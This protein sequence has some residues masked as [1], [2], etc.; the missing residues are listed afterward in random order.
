MIVIL[1]VPVV[2]SVFV[3]RSSA[4]DNGLL[5]CWNF[6]EGSGSTATDSS[7]NGNTGAL[8]NGPAWVD[9]KRGKALSFDGRS[10][11]MSYPT[12]FS[13]GISE[14]SVMAWINSPLNQSGDII[15]HGYGG[16]F[17][18]RTGSTSTRTNI[19]SFEVHL[20]D[21]IWYASSSSVLF[22]NT[23]YFVAGVWSK[24][25]SLR[26][27]IDGVLESETAVPSLDLTPLSAGWDASIGVYD[28]AHYGIDFWNGIV[29]EARIYNRALTQ[30]EVQNDMGVTRT[31]EH[32][33]DFSVDTGL[34]T[35]A[36]TAY[37]DSAEE[38][39]VLT[40]AV[41]AQAGAI[42]F[43]ETVSSSFTACFK[44]WIG[45]TT[46]TM[47]DGLAMMFY[48]Q[49][50]LSLPTGGYL[51]FSS[52]G[53]GV[54][55]DTFQN[56]WDV[57][58]SHVALI[59]D[60]VENHLAQVNDA[61]VRDQ[62]WHNV[63][64]NVVPSSVNVYIDG[65]RILQ[66][67]GTLDSTHNGFGFT[68]ATGEASWPVNDKHIIDDFSIKA[69]ASEFDV[70]ISPA[71]INTSI[72]GAADCTITI[73]NQRGAADV[74]NIS[75]WG[76]NSTW[77]SLSS[78][79]VSLMS[80]EIVHIKL[81]ISVPEDPSAVGSYE[82]S[83]L[84]Y[85]S[86]RMEKNVSS[87]LIV[88]L[89]P[90]IT[91]L[92]PN[93]GATIAST[94]ILFSWH[95]SSNASS[96]VYI[97]QTNDPTFNKAVGEPGSTHF[98][99]AYNL[100]RNADYVWYAYG[101]TTYGNASS[102]TRT[103]HVS[104]GV[105]FVQDEY[106]FN[107]ERD[108]AQHGTVAVINTD[109]VSH[110]L[111]LQA[112]NP[113]EDLIVGF[114]GEGSVDQ[115][116]TLSPSETK[117]VDFFIHAQDAMQQNYTFTAKLTNLGPEE[118]VD[119]ALI[120]VTVRQP[121]TNLTLTEVSTDP[122]TLSKTIV[123][124]NYGDTLTDLCIDTGDELNGKV[125]FQPAV[126][127]AY[128][129][130]GGSLTFKA[131]P[132]LT[133]DFAGC[134][135]LIL[136]I[137][138]GQ[139][140]ASLQVNFTLPPGKSV[141][142][143][144]IPQ[145]EI[146]FSQYYDFDESPNTNPLPDRLVES[147]LENGTIV[148][149]CQIVVDVYQ[150]GYPAVAA[151]VSLTV[152]N[153]TDA[154]E[155]VEYCDTDLLGKAM[156]IVCGKIGNYSYEARLPDHGLVTE[157]RQ[158]SVSLN[159][160]YEMHPNQI[161]W[162]NVSDAN[163]T[164]VFD[165]NAS[166][167]VLDQAPFVFKARKE[168]ADANSTVVLC[169]RW[170]Y[171]ILKKIYIP[172]YVL[173]DTVVFETSCVPQGNYS[174]VVLYFSIVGG[175]YLSTPL[176]VTNK[177]PS[178][179][180]IQGNY[181]YY[182]PLSYNSTAFIRLENE[183]TVTVRDETV[184]FDLIDIEPAEPDQYMFRY[185]VLSKENTQTVFQFHAG[186]DSG[187]SYDCSI[188]TYLEK[189]RPLEVNFTVPVYASNLSLVRQISS[190]MS[191]GSSSVVCVTKV[192]LTYFYDTRIWV[193]AQWGWLDPILGNPIVK[194]TVTCG[195]GVLSDWYSMK[196]DEG[197]PVGDFV[198]DGIEFATSDD[199]LKKQIIV[200]KWGLAAMLGGGVAIG[201]VICPEASL[202]AGLA[203]A[204]GVL[205]IGD[206]VECAYDWTKTLG[207]A[208]QNSKGYGVSSET[209]TCVH[210]CTNRPVVT[211]PV[212]IPGGIIMLS[213]QGI[214]VKTA[215]VIARFSL[216]WPRETYRPHNVHV[217]VNGVEIGS[218]M[219]VIPEGYYVF[220]FDG[221]LLSYAV[222]G[223]AQ[224]VVTMQMDDLNGG[225][226][227]VSSDLAIVLHTSCL[228]LAVVATNQTEAYQLAALLT[229][230][231]AC[232]PD[233]GVYAEKIAFSEDQPKEGDNVR[234]TA[235][236]FNFGTIGFVSIPVDLY[237]DSVKVA[238]SIVPAIP[239][240][241]SQ[242]INLTWKAVGGSHSIM[243]KVNDAQAI[244]EADFSNNQAQTSMT[245]LVDDV[246]IANVTYAKN[247]VVQGFS[248]NVSVT[249][250]NDGDFTETFNVTVY[251]NATIIAS[252]NVTLSTGDST[253][254]TFTCNTTGLAKG[255]YTISAYATPVQGETDTADNMFSDGWVFI[256][257]PG[258]INADNTVN[259]I[260]IV[261]VALAFGAVPANPNWDPNADINGD[262]VINIVDI[263]IVAL[264]FGETG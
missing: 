261:R 252:Q 179:M 139:T 71:T 97:K 190:A 99:C 111:L 197:G 22:P 62:A 28:A 176:N 263:V 47:T 146:E 136:A 19:V 45:N 209:R 119:Y 236:I 24:G 241:S 196:V 184:S 214:N 16:E 141:F 75:I 155:R 38:Y 8:C 161:T 18:L 110:D 140:M 5:A 41:N 84:V 89:N 4:G 238:S 142:L 14:L 80:G 235:Q 122:V 105:G 95:T 256:S 92:E 103:F 7:G 260:D 204:T 249:V 233:F 188:D 17:V 253:T 185:L 125:Y 203:V 177:D 169:L 36:G 222:D 90:I 262:E 225:H 239:A 131:I 223:I 232:L 237:V 217:L 1:L 37:R 231:T 113:Y 91:D 200:G 20:S 174:A 73:D 32:S 67:N 193:G 254:V 143:V 199:L 3:I 245:V 151:N 49:R 12:L 183:R 187:W 157:R 167:V 48:K 216:P 77:F 195:G 178:S 250:A 129:S 70:A 13:A 101:G 127:H 163:S 228:D 230:T 182:S 79:S 181:T 215:S 6:D 42:W 180:Y 201:G 244:P 211:T 33:D 65:G 172:G 106:T 264:H 51:G 27:Y 102:D 87:Q 202:P 23:W 152:R 94:N 212:E 63:T 30:Q 10:N 108:Y 43:T 86:V 114:V 145:V 220:P 115:N 57:P 208:A 149:A 213:Q 168:N 34:W 82:F 59:K 66:W 248:F 64:I 240:F 144:S 170:E 194:A 205:F 68:A 246:A 53:Y 96:E 251:A 130:T 21:W 147:Y 81:S 210:Y 50:D 29:D 61:R 148:F 55:F 224:N 121:N 219:N 35:Y 52:L 31:I 117:T 173:N 26:I 255:N 93:N 107:V 54:E 166:S 83:A 9:G 171:D 133:A 186:T 257:I 132:V 109:N 158:F 162:L 39:V 175:L 15:Y 138:A 104:N 11:Y 258:D 137:G 76:L 154:I 135:G 227:V 156:F 123:A 69:P 128:V 242:M 207:E 198:L 74:F 72:G 234:I 112:L 218:L 118:I 78:N 191:M 60:G 88:I 259:I 243:I 247:V 159:T 164:I 160:L 153:E 229:G 98:V 116:V 100:S 120:S 165:E 124:T 44:Y 221:T 192:A 134:E 226:Y 85:D 2:S 25:S 206:I 150:D 40:E 58:S 189:G 126:Y 56:S 46:N